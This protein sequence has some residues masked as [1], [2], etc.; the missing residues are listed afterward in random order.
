MEDQKKKSGRPTD[1]IVLTRLGTLLDRPGSEFTR[2]SLARAMGFTPSYVSALCRDRN[3]GF[4]PALK[5]QEA[6]K[7]KIKVRD[8]VGHCADCKHELT[9]VAK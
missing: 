2:S 7:G 3:I 1:N 6:T 8:I 4:E 9:K 5:I